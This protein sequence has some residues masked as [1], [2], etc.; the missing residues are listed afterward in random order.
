MGSRPVWGSDEFLEFLIPSVRGVPVI[1]FLLLITMFTIVIGPFNYIALWKRRRLYLLVLTIPMIALFTSLALFAYSAVA[2]GFS[3]KSR[4]RTVTFVDQQAKSAVSIGRIALYAGLAP[5]DG[6]HFSQD[7][8][9]LP[10]WPE[11]HVF[12]SATTDWT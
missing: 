7:T 12:E 2:H 4:A 3:T 9:V 10:I 11:D 1:A 6:L 8:G 5:S